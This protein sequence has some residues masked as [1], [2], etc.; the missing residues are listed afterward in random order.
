MSIPCRETETARSAPNQALVG[1]PGSRGRLATP[2]LVL[3][4][5]RLEGNIAAM[6][7]YCR[8]AGLALRPHAKTHKSVAIARA[9]VAAGAIGIACA[10]LGE[11]ECMV[12]GEIA[13]VLLT[14]PAVGAGR[15]ERLVALNGR[16][17]GLLAV[18]DHPDNV[19]A[20]AKAAEA[21][22]RPVALLVDFDIGLHRT[23]A[24]SIEAAVALAERIA[25][26]N[27]LRFAGVQAYAGQLQHVPDYAE[28]LAKSR[29]Q[30]ERLRALVEALIQRR[31]APAVVSGGGTG[32]H[33][34]DARARAFGELQAGSYVFMDVDYDRITLRE[35]ANRPPFENALFVQT[36]VV[37][38]NAPGFVTTDA[39]LKR[40]ATDGPKP[41]IAAGAPSGA[42]YR[43]Q[44]DE[45]GAVVFAAPGDSLPL[46]AV[47]SCVVPHC[48]PTVNLYDHYHCVRGDTLVDI[49]PV[50]A[51]GAI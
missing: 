14:S 34:I 3:D 35:A 46:G 51:R 30:H 9:Q 31:L 11:A 32:T 1:V 48:D 15:V 24:A 49:W 40:F 29:Q 39:G 25:R 27:S 8:T 4:L 47:V 26:A 6:A 18:A 28:R 33:D 20:I 36:T 13:G 50:D 2:A 23:G 44:G 41:A 7:G 45:H 10:T 12:E 43:Y 19:D 16:A 21:E 17:K 38:A 42:T 37:S 22:G 5:D